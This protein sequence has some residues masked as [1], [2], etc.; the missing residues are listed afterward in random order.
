M[1]LYSYIFILLAV[2]VFIYLII[3]F[4]KRRI[5]LSTLLIAGIVILLGILIAIFPDVSIFFAEFLGFTRGLDF[6][7]IVAIIILLYIFTLI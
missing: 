7:F 5:T 2:L 6:V 4:K 3:R 1:Y